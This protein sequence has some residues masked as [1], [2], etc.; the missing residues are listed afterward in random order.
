MYLTTDKVSNFLIYKT[1]RYQKKRVTVYKLCKCAR[2]QFTHNSLYIK[3]YI[4]FIL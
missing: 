3:A 1:I 2:I 4:R